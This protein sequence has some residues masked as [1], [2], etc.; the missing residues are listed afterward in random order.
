MAPDEPRGREMPLLVYLLV[1]SF[2]LMLLSGAMFMAG[3]P[4]APSRALFLATVVIWVALGIWAIVDG[5][6][7]MR[8][9]AAAHAM[10][11]AKAEAKA[12]SE[13]ESETES[14]A[15]TESK[16]E[17]VAEA[18]AAGPAAS[19]SPGPDDGAKAP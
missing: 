9:V 2:L 16:T 10:A 15:E 5:R 11:K 12:E 13:T 6:L 7:E 1:A 8:R 19:P 14:E 3:L 17:A 4:E 18:E